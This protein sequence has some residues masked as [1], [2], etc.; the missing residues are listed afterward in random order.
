LNIK[1][2]DLCVLQFLK[3]HT[4]DHLKLERNRFYI[5]TVNI[6]G[7]FSDLYLEI[8]AKVSGLPNRSL[9]KHS[10]Y[11]RE[12]NGRSP[13]CLQSFPNGTILCCLLLT[14]SI[15]Y[16]ACRKGGLLVP[17]DILTVNYFLSAKM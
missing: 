14:P 17:K 7:Q 12:R 16:P 4:L 15:G 3:F 11:R 1:P 13:Q 6:R 8:K 9:E 2:L 5:A 10:N